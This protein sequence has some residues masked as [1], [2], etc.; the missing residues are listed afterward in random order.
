M[1]KISFKSYLI[2]CFLLLLPVFVWNII[3]IN[4]LPKEFQAEVFWKDIPTFIKYA[5]NSLRIFLF[6][7][8]VFIPIN[9]STTVQKKGLFLYLFGIILYFS[10]WLFL[11][12]FP[13]LAISNSLL[14]FMAPAY[15]PL[16][17]LVG[18][19]LIGKSFYFNLPY[20]RWFFI[21][22]SI[23][24]LLFHNLHTYIIYLRTH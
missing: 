24:F 4:K 21:M 5:E 10:S 2:N 22:I 1:K 15:T 6:A 7:L 17:W 14:L 23:L 12:Y 9:I 8:T 3:F 11:M 19:G 16:F 13:D 20:K 18:I